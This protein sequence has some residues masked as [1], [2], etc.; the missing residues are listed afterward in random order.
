MGEDEAIAL[1]FPPLDDKIDYQHGALELNFDMD[2]IRKQEE[3]E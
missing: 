1:I 3:S 2:I